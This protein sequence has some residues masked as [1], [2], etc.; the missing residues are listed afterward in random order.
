M[1]VSISTDRR[2]WWGRLDLWILVFLT[3]LAAAI[4][5]ARLERPPVL[6]DDAFTFWRVCGSFR[7]MVE[8][9]RDD[10]FTP[11]H[12]EILWWIKEGGPLP[13]GL[14]IVPGGFYLTPEVMRFIP[15]VCGTLMPLAMY[16]LGR[17]LLTRR[18]SLIAAGITATSA[19]MLWFSRDMKM[20]MPLWL[21]TTVCV[22][23]L[24]W[25][26]RTGSWTAWLA[27]IAAGLAAVGHHAVA[28][29][30]IGLTPLI[31][32]TAR[33]FRWT[34]TLL[35]FAGMGII[36]AGPAGYYLGF[37]KWTERS[38]GIMPGATGNVK[39]DAD[40]ELSG[41]GWIGT[42]PDSEG[43]IQGTIS[44]WLTSFEMRRGMLDFEQQRQDRPLSIP[45]RAAWWCRTAMTVTGAFLAVGLMPWSRRLLRYQDDDSPVERAWRVVLWL[46]SWVLLIA[47][48]FFYCRSAAEPGTPWV[49]LSDPRFLG[50]M[51]SWVAMTL[52]IAWR[53]QALSQH[54]VG[55]AKV[56]VATVVIV[57]LC[58]IAHGVIATLRE[59]AIR[60][61]PDI[62][63]QTIWHTRYVAIV[64]PAVILLMA[65]LLDRVPT[66]PLRS[67][68]VTVFVAANLVNGIARIMQESQFRFDLV[69]QD[70][71][72]DRPNGDVRTYVELGMGGSGPLPTTPY[73]RMMNAYYAVYTGRVPTSPPDFRVG[74]T[75]PFV[76]GPVFERIREQINLR[77]FPNLES[78]ATDV[79]HAAGVKHVITWS[80]LR[81][82]GGDM[83]PPEMAGFRVVSDDVYTSRWG[84]TWSEQ[85]RLRRTEYVR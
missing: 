68:A 22:G 75:W 63:W 82:I 2:P 35:M 18:A 60:R 43:L 29:L 28:M 69:W 77:P 47:Y 20:Y 14:R 24:I 16:F 72:S 36:S 7:E 55:V 44:T 62:Q 58:W 38:G 10:G 8:T 56:L 21:F 64:W 45:Q 66:W 53:R 67:I 81:Q 65:A 71:W 54:A 79:Q 76:Y 30:V 57:G 27:W 49:V 78:V 12:Y 25:W 52:F 17:Q 31:A 37:N 41:L 5:F 33:R 70:V 4:R 59:A 13:L 74:K 6:P 1:N 50:A 15:A 80:R 73:W 84:W 9:L 23:C 40:W 3:L 19:Y 61:N 46:G 85:G 51:M 32:L 83:T 39:P 26:L 48:G 42:T 11:L 34:T